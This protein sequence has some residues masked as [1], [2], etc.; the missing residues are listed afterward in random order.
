MSNLSPKVIEVLVS[1]A[2]DVEVGAFLVLQ[3]GSVPKTP[4]G[5]LGRVELRQRSMEDT[6]DNS[7]IVR[8]KTWHSLAT[9]NEFSEEQ[10]IGSWV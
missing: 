3:Q 10:L 6:W 4:S 9:G 8:K 7:N 2:C 1:N 5:K